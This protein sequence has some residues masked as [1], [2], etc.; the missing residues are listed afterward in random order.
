MVLYVAQSQKNMEI[1]YAD[2][3]ET[4]DKFV[5]SHS[6]YFWDKF[7]NV[8]LRD[9]SVYVDALNQDLSEAARLDKK[10]SDVPKLP[11]VNIYNGDELILLSTKDKV[12]FSHY[13]NMLFQYLWNLNTENTIP[14]LSP[15]A[16]TWIY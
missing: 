13:Q 11:I 1:Y 15:N 6:D 4:I 3:R 7:T 8:S 10:Y 9:L 5:Q 14:A 2:S 12:D 16:E